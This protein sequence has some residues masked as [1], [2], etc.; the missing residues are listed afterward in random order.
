MDIVDVACILTFPSILLVLYAEY[1]KMTRNYT[2]YS[3]IKDMTW[4]SAMVLVVVFPVIEEVLFRWYLFGKFAEYDLLFN[5]GGF[6][7]LHVFNWIVTKSI[8]QTL[9]QMY[10][11]VILGVICYDVRLEYECIVYPILVHVLWNGV[12]VGMVKYICTFLIPTRTIDELYISDLLKRRV[13]LIRSIDDN[14]V[15]GNKTFPIKT[16]NDEFRREYFR[17]FDENSFRRKVPIK[18]WG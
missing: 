16:V 17:V 5:V 10:I 9:L 18:K 8:P 2:N 4:W 12:M 13:F 1:V 14:G 11:T 6:S 15:V 3:S 7:L